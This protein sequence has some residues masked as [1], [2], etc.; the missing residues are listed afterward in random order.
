[1][2]NIVSYITVVRQMIALVLDSGVLVL[3]SILYNDILGALKNAG[4]ENKGLECE[5]VDKIANESRRVYQR[6][7][8]TVKRSRMQFLT[9]VSHSIGAH[10]SQ[11]GIVSIYKL[12]Q[13]R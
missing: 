10:C 12:Q 2:S 9:A 11:K 8:Y 4:V 1:M 13:Q 5:L 6:S 3:A 7:L